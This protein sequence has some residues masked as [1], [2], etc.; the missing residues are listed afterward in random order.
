MRLNMWH[1]RPPEDAK[2]RHSRP[3]EAAIGLAGRQVA[4]SR[5]KERQRT[6]DRQVRGAV[7]SLP[8]WAATRYLGW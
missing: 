4:D 6:A 7:I 2:Q 8:A 5:L 3:E 1:R